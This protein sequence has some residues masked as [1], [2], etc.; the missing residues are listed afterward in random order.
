MSEAVLCFDEGKR[1]LFRAGSNYKKLVR[2][3]KATYA[4]QANAQELM[5]ARLQGVHCLVLAA[6]AEP[7][8]AAEVAALHA[9][10]D[11]G[12]SLVVLSGEGGPSA[13]NSNLNDVV[14]KC[15][16]AGAGAEG[17]G[18]GQQ[19]QAAAGSRQQQQRKCL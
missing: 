10:V 13:V 2:R 19:Q 8:S 18:R 12:G 5:P 9:Y 11:G 14:S 15:V 17:R 3:L 6:P 7:L 4:I 1:E 16:G